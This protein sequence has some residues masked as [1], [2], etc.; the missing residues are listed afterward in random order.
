ML[1]ITCKCSDVCTTDVG[2]DRLEQLVSPA[3]AG[4]RGPA[5]DVHALHK[6]SHGVCA[7]YGVQLQEDEDWARVLLLN[8]VH[9]SEG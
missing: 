2:G 7:A 9:Y 3:G 4:R 8:F 5:E 6:A 1:T